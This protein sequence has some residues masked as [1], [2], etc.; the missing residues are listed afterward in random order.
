MATL[1]S[2]GGGGKVLFVKGA[3][4]VVFEHCDR[5]QIGDTGHTSI[6]RDHF[7]KASDELARR[8]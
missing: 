4:E 2:A 1:H 7:L 5:Q 8:G 6:N 3:P